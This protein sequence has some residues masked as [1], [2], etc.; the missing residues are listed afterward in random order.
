MVPGTIRTCSMPRRSSTGQRQSANCVD[1][2][3]VP[4]DAVD[5]NF[6]PAMATAKRPR[7]IAP[8]YDHHS[9]WCQYL[10]TRAPLFFLPPVSKR[11]FCAEQV[12]RLSLDF[13]N[14]R[15]CRNPRL[16]CGRRCLP[17]TREWFSGHCPRICRRFV[18]SCTVLEV[19]LIRL[20]E[21]RERSDR[22]AVSVFWSRTS[23]HPQRKGGALDLL[24]RFP[25]QSVV[26]LPQQ[27]IAR[28]RFL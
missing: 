23:V 8:H 7:N 11:W 20:L 2:T 21:M 1:N 22:R 24:G 18:F 15:S 14:R 12:L 4:S 9:S 27:R 19:A 16:F 25:L 6:F 10:P 26:D 3:S 17:T 5:A 13:S 28:E